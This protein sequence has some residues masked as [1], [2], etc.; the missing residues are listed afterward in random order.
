MSHRPPAISP[1][2]FKT[3]EEA[4]LWL[5][6]LEHEDS[7]ETR[8]AF[9][10][11]V[12]AGA[13]NLEEFLFAQAVWKEFDHLD[14]SL[15]ADT[16]E[17][18]T[19]SIVDLP[20]TRDR[21][22]AVRTSSP[23]GT[24]SAPTRPRRQAWIAAIAACFCIV[25]VASLAWHSLWSDV[26]TTR[27]GDQKTVKLD[28]G[29]VVYM[30]TDSRIRVR[31]SEHGRTVQLLEG[32]ALFDVAHDKARPFI[33]VTDSARV[34][35]VGTRFNVYRNSNTT[36]RVAVVEG[37]VQVT[38]ELTSANPTGPGSGAAA[39]TAAVTPTTDTIRLAAGDEAEID[40]GRISKTSEPNIVRAVAWQ[41]R[42]LIF[43]G[44][45]VAEVAAQFNRYNS[46]HI[47]VDDP[48]IRA[49]RIT[50]T[51][52]AD[53]FTP[54]IRFLSHDPRVTVTTNSREVLIRA[55]TASDTTIE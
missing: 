22:E 44:D 4:A 51:F 7:A 49:R 37:L 8:A 3:S 35:A 13:G 10:A 28:D 18:S 24:T 26:Y 34:R 42:R 23:A 14:P 45:S 17:M 40:H 16:E 32:E 12:R 43:D 6:R 15:R 25:T 30:N 31:Y 41:T 29:S 1:L 52:D 54:F 36:T 9:A 5:H 21:E 39:A 50:G 33:V 53:D 27:P 11:W 2:D 47:R 48:A 38:S 55:R 19:G 20:G 46:I